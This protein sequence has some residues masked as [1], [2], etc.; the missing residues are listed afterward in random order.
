V[1]QYRRK[2]VEIIVHSSD[3]GGEGGK[4]S[5][6]Q[7][8][9]RLPKGEEGKQ[10][11]TPVALL[12]R[13]RRAKPQRGASECGARRYSGKAAVRVR[14][15]A[16][17]NISF[18]ERRLRKKETHKSEQNASLIKVPKRG[19]SSINKRKRKG[20]GKTTSKPQS[21]GSWN[22]EEDGLQ[23]AS[24]KGG[25]TIFL[26]PVAKNSFHHDHAKKGAGM[27]RPQRGI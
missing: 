16:S 23:K 7:E 10:E 17:N 15:K 13:G 8:G 2:N 27:V 18:E 22:H 12:T 25:G 14:G 6:L 21:G 26:G 9:F 1:Q 11:K 19:E 20:K 3:G 5:A 24:R 4:A